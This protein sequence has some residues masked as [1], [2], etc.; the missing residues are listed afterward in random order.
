M[1]MLKLT[2]RDLTRKTVLGGS[3][4]GRRLLADIVSTVPQNPETEHCFLD[5]AEVQIATAS[6]LRES[7]L[8]FR[9]WALERTPPLYLVVANANHD[10]LEELEIVL[11]TQGEAMWVCSMDKLDRVSDARVIG[12]LDEIQ[13]RTF[14]LVQARGEVDAPSLSREIFDGGRVAQTAWNNRLATL[15]S[16]GL[17]LERQSG[18]SKTYKLLLEAM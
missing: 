4:P 2:V 1:K 5:F 10:I 11:N 18:K 9:K 8:A 6:Y 12:K 17:L 16:R 15:A 14:E 7:V 3:I 13:Q